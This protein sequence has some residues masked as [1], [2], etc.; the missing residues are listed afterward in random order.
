VPLLK[1]RCLL[2]KVEKREKSFREAGT[3]REVIRED[4]IPSMTVFVADHPENPLDL[5]LKNV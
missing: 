5:Q 3:F 4:K 1:K 2:A